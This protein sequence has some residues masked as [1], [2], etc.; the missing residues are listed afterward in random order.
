M[1]SS[2]R[3][4]SDATLRSLH[5][6]SGASSPAPGAS[7]AGSRSWR[8]RRGPCSGRE[9]WTGGSQQDFGGPAGVR[10]RPAD[11]IVRMHFSGCPASCAQPQIADIGFRGETAHVG[12]EIVEAVDIGLGGSLGTDAAFGDWVAG[13]VPV[14][15]VVDSLGGVVGRY[16]AER[17]QDER[18]HEWA[19]RSPVE[20]LQSTLRAGVHDATA[21][22]DGAVPGEESGT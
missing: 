15:Q 6:S 8:R 13:A 11:A 10:G 5:P 2:A 21:T 16:L 4:S 7:S 14:E 1:T 9:R 19:R 20:T 17:D 18:F 12:D 22:A 3:S